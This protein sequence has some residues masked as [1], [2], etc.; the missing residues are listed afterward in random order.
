MTVKHSNELVTRALLLLLA[1]TLPS[2]GGGAGT[3]SPPAKQA[4]L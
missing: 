1:V 4:Q 2:Y 3:E